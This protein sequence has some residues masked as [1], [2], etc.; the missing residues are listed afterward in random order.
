MDA[1]AEE[2]S[3]LDEIVLMPIY[4][5]RE[6]PMP[7]I[8]STALLEKVN[9]SHKKLVEPQHMLEEIAQSEIEVLLTIGAGDIDRLVSHLKTQ[10]NPHK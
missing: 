3:R 4:P 9:N 2:L 10:L 8:T 1:F 7:G 6:Q 5:A